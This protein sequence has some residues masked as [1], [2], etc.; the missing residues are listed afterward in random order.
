MRL[1]LLSRAYCHL[2]DDMLAAVQPIARAHEVSIDVIDVD[3][4]GNAALEAAWGE[5]VPALFA[6]APATGTL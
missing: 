4:P 1:T 2:C 5:K 3:A 6:G